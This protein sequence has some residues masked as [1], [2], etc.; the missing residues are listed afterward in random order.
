MPA[1]KTIGD[2]EK[3][4]RR[5]RPSPSNTSTYSKEEESEMDAEELDEVEEVSS[6]RG[7]TAGKG[8]ATPSRRKQIEAEEEEGNVAT[9]TVGGLREYF[10]GVRSE[11][12]KV[13][14]PTREETRRLTIIV[15]IALIISSL[16]L[17]A[18][19]LIFTELFKVGLNTPIILLAV[20][21]IAVA[22]G[23]FFM[24]YSS[25]RSTY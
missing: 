22:G 11:L 9:R 10:E 3:T 20:M 8:Y 14:W 4:G 12:G 25:R 23:I 19:S 5:R 17:G 16:V 7:I 18:I 21:L 2:E 1:D 24:R 6:T 13:I 15:L